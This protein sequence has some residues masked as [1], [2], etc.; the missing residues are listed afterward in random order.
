MRILMFTNT[1]TPVT[2]GLERSIL[3]FRAEFRRRG[4]KVLVVAPSFADMP[5]RE[6]DVIR[7]PSIRHVTRHDFSLSLPVPP[8]TIRE[9][10][11]FRPEIVHAHHP[12]ILGDTAL[13]V[14][15]RCRIP[16]VFTHHILFEQYTHYL[17]VPLPGA[18]QFLVGLATGYA[19]L[20][21][22][23]FAP[24]ESLAGHLRACGVTAPIAVVPTGVPVERFTRGDGQATRQ[25]LG[26]PGDAFV[27]GHV[28][29]LAREK[30]L[31]FLGRALAQFLR[32]EPAAHVVLAG[33]GP[34]AEPVEHLFYQAGVGARLHRLGVLA[35]RQLI[36][37]YHA[38][39]VF[40]FASHSETQGIV[41]VEAMAA[42][43]P[44]VAIDAP[45]VREVVRDGV[46]GRLLARQHLDR[47]VEALRWISR[48]STAERRRLR[49]AA[50]DTAGEFSTARCADRA[51]HA[52]REAQR[53][54][55]ACDSSG[56]RQRRTG[57]LVRADWDLL[58]SFSHAARA[59]VLPEAAH[60]R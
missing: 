8:H 54:L 3:S 46:N 59:A 18:A 5:E 55:A 7:I 43:A 17:P 44:V 19:N 37:A 14:A 34:L 4:H 9:V 12:F 31:L 56:N 27:V 41:L 24:S 42:G 28:G 47:Y 15:R 45:G 10:I 25:A 57:A 60:A 26:I 35:P 48:R 39:D 23:V 38:M 52:Y 29:R 36:N 58:K 33:Q 20:S 51:L 30:N 13:R 53:R 22:Q 49:A 40:A 32:G 21:D 6:S 50:I 16:L 1:Y 2:G 11:A